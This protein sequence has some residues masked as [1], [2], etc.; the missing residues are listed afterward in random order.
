M[1]E[2]RT[3]R[4]SKDSAT[5]K[6]E[7]GF[8][9]RIARLVELAG[10]VSR[11]ARMCGVSEAVVRKWRD[12]LSEPSRTHLAQVARGAGVSVAWLVTGDGPMQAQPPRAL[13]EPPGPGYVALRAPGD[14]T[15]HEAGD[16]DALMFNE[17]W[18][19]LELGA[20][21]QDLRLVRIRSD[22]MAPTLRSGDIALVDGRSTWPDGE[23]IY[24]M[25]MNGTLLVKRLQALPGGVLKVTSDN[26]AFDS[27]RLT[28]SQVDGKNI[29]IVGRI[30]WLGHR[31]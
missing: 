3:K 4:V 27:F 19:R 5:E 14:G 28:R 13:G 9:A 7:A 12:G 15:G 30:A 10:G 21:P 17:D 1:A 2:R 8:P 29:A 24:L 25:R 22:S 31:L 20:R 11:L 16:G 6:G 23:G 26:P 18:L